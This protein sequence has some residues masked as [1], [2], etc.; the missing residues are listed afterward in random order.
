MVSGDCR[1]FM[2]GVG[3]GE[4]AASPLNPVCWPVPGARDE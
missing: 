3:P 2:P 1:K 4:V